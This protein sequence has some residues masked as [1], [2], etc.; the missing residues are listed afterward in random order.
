MKK[1]NT[2]ILLILIVNCLFAFGCKKTPQKQKPVEVTD[3]KL[4]QEVTSSDFNYVIKNF[5]PVDYSF[6]WE[7]RSYT[8]EYSLR[9]NGS[10]YN[11]KE[12]DTYLLEYLPVTNDY[13]F[14]Y[15]KTEMI[16]KCMDY[17]EEYLKS[18]DSSDYYEPE[19]SRFSNQ[20]VIDG[21]YLYAYNQ[22]NLTDGLKVYKCDNLET[23]K[24]S[25][26]EYQMVYCARTKPMIIK[27]NLS[28]KVDV[29]KQLTIYKREVLSFEKEKCVVGYEYIDDTKT[30]KEYANLDFDYVGEM[31]ECYEVSTTNKDCL[32]YPVLGSFE[33][34]NNCYDLMPKIKV[35]VED[36]KKYL[37][38][39]RYT[40]MMTN[41][42]DSTVDLIMA[43]P[44]YEEDYKSFMIT[45]YFGPYRDEFSNAYVK[46]YKRDYR[47]E[48]GYLVEENCYL[49]DYEKVVE[50]IH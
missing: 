34:Y 4:V 18:Y 15:L 27:S 28:T 21:K 40:S 17:M 9:S 31:I 33:Y 1:I 39:P 37:D 19:F 47:D 11:K 32:Y 22:M 50:I 8:K 13:Y 36:G 5:N 2:F 49:Y 20:D 43:G 3:E 25:L 23:V 30:E 44:L 10:Q 7:G 35:I 6:L 48:N 42:T 24:F 29:N 26:N 16:R 41:R 38:L 14:V 46:G 45:N 12:I